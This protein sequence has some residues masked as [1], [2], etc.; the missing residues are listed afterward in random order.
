[1]L[2]QGRHPPPVCGVTDRVILG[3]ST[4]A[5]CVGVGERVVV[6]VRVAVFVGLAVGVCVAVIEGV[7]VVV[8]T[9]LKTRSPTARRNRKKPAIR[10]S[11]MPNRAR[12]VTFF[13]LEL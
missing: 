7:G 5:D 8:G 2:S 12:L 13:I 4:V 1:M 6:F 3:W 10:S 9:V 11:T